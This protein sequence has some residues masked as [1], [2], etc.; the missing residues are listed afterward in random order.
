MSLYKRL[1]ICFHCRI[2]KYEIYFNRGTL[3]YS[4]KHLLLF[5]FRISPYEKGFFDNTSTS[6]S[7]EKGSRLA[8]QD[9]IYETVFSGNGRSMV[10]TIGIQATSSG[11]RNVQFD[12]VDEDD[13]DSQTF[14]LLNSFW[15]MIASLLQQGTDLLPR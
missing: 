7:D 11:S 14:T 5:T 10:R 2:F 3:S 8:K 13:D 12:G 4:P 9:P 15:F 6:K 1:G